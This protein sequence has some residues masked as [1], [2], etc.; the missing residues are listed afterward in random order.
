VP[1]K[2]ASIYD[3]YIH[4]NEMH[5]TTNKANQEETKPVVVCGY[6]ISMLGMDLKD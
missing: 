3:I 4:R 5:M 6:C 2:A 1:R